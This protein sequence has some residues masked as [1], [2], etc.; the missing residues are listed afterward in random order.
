MSNDAFDE[1]L[2]LQRNASVEGFDWSHPEDLW[3]KLAEEIGELREAVGHAHRQEE[4][5]DILF[6][7]V[8]LAR[9][10][11]V[12]PAR[13]LESTNRKFH[14]RYAHVMAHAAQ[15]PPLG[16][17]ERLVQMEILWQEAKRLEKKPRT[18]DSYK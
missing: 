16:D 12:D 8:N 11:G 13:G 9:H 3:D 14:Q 4:L 6:M 2:R 15:L 1:A 10:L 5:G 18:A 7:V 17:P